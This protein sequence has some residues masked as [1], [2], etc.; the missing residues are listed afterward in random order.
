MG[1]ARNLVLE[2]VLIRTLSLACYS[3]S[4]CWMLEKKGLR[5]NMEK[6]NFIVSGINLDLLNKSGKNPCVVYLT[7][8]GRHSIF[9][10]EMH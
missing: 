1:T 9:C 7:G 5:V 10:G 8:E 6:T 3:S 4:L 2:W